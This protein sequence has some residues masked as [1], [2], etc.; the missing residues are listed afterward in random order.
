MEN[1]TQQNIPPVQPLPQT[2]PVIPPSTNWSKI[3]LFTILGLII[4]AGSVFVGIQIGKNQTSNQQPI[5]TQPTANPTQ[6]AVNPTAQPTANPTTDP[7]ADW[8]TYTNQVFTIKLPEQFEYDTR[9]SNDPSNMHFSWSEPK[10]T[11]PIKSIDMVI[12]YMQGDPNLM[13]CKTDEECFQ[14]YSKSF[15]VA[16]YNKIS[17]TLNGKQVNGFET[18]NDASNV[19]IYQNFYPLSHNGKSFTFDI[20]MSAP[21]V[22]QAKQLVSEVNQ[23]LSTFKFTN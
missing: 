8:K 18:S 6:T 22:E 7:T 10:N 19:L 14:G 1:D 5:V 4:V 17:T 11:T 16:G 3:L 2:P 23:T 9:Y 21:S 20:Q 12:G 15:S 13:S